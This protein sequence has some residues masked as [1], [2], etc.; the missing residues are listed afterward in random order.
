MR[1]TANFFQALSRRGGRVLGGLAAVV[2]LMPLPVLALTFTSP[3]QAATVVSGA[4]TPTPATFSDTTSGGDDD[5][6]VNMGN[7]QGQTKTAISAI[8][9]AWTITVPSAGE[10]IDFAEQFASSF[11]EAGV[12]LTV[13]VFDSKGNLVAAPLTF[14]QSTNSTTFTTISANQNVIR[15]LKGGNYILTVGILYVTN[16]KIGGWK[17]ISKHHFEIDGL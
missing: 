4:P 6:F 17:T 9:L 12:A 3:W 2:L 15:T 11:K 14:G 5:L 10:A 8:G 13:A 16:N 1:D 7:Y